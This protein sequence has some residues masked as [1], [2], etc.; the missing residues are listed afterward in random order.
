MKPKKSLVLAAGTAMALAGC[1]EDTATQL[2]GNAPDAAAQQAC[3][4][5]VRSTTGNPDVSVIRSTFSEAGTAVILRVG[6]AG[7]WRCIAYRDG[8]TAGIESLTDEGFL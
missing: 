8:T 5:D 2:P 3:V 4:R 7:T 6:P 1:V